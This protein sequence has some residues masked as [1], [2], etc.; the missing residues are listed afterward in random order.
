MRFQAVHLTRFGCFTDQSVQFGPATEA[1]DFHI[2]YGDNEAGKSTLRDAITAFLYGI[3]ARTDHNFLHD[4]MALQIGA[5]LDLSTGPRSAIRVKANR[6]SLRGPDGAVLNED[7]LSR[8][9]LGLT[10]S[11]FVN[12]FSLD[13]HA[14]LEGGADILQAKGD[15]GAL[16]FAGASGISS[17]SQTIDRAR[18]TANAFFKPRASSS[19]LAQKLKRLK[20]IDAELKSLDVHAPQFRRIKLAAADAQRAYDEAAQALKENRAAYEKQKLILQALEPWRE[21]RDLQTRLEAFGDAPPADEQALIRA[22]ALQTERVTLEDTKSQLEE[23]LERAEEESKTF[24]PPP[25]QDRLITGLEA[26]Q[27]D[28]LEARAS[29][30]RLDLPSRHAELEDVNRQINGAL[31]RLG[32]DPKSDPEP[33]LISKTDA[34]RIAAL[35]DTGE[36][37]TTE[38]D[39]AHSELEN[40]KSHLALAKEELSNLSEPQDFTALDDALTTYRRDLDTDHLRE[41]ESGLETAQRRFDRAFAA[42]APWE[43]PRGR[44]ESACCPLFVRA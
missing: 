44:L 27:V 29:T 34:A 15:L 43:G 36:T 10:E 7:T 12:L 32:L 21:L 11:D 26:L 30:A 5:D 4:Y 37:L 41:M 31:G 23:Q 20:D 28:E 14:L 17:V 24:Q 9:L 18:E 33:F 16:L 19:Q 40:A 2:I 8:E 38:N 1:P 22:R 42:L 3:P 25:Y 13:L 35:A 39:R 6:E